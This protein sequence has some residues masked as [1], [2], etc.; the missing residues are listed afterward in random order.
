MVI[1]SLG[2]DDMR[3]RHASGRNGAHPGSVHRSHRLHDGP[4]PVV[5]EQR[6]ELHTLV[7]AASGLV[8]PSCLSNLHLTSRIQ[9]PTVWPPATEA[10]EHPEQRSSHDR[11]LWRWPRFPHLKTHG[12]DAARL[13]VPSV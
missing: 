2:D 13:R 12:V 5:A 9:R 11:H 3:G 6:D 4:A 10:S 7:S 1:L 8:E